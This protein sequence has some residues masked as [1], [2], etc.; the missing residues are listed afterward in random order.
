MSVKGF[1]EV[2][3]KVDTKRKGNSMTSLVS[4]KCSWCHLASQLLTVFTVKRNQR[5]SV[6]KSA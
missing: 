3:H 5:M 2:S 6:L 4:F 1:L